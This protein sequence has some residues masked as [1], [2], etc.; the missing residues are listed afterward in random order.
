MFVYKK[1]TNNPITIEVIA[2]KL[3]LSQISLNDMGEKNSALYLSGY[4]IK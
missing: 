3:K 1:V 4:A 2:N